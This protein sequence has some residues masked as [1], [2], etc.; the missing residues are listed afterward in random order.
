MRDV[1]ETYKISESGFNAEVKITG[2][3]GQTKTYEIVQHTIEPATAA[4]LEHIKHE[5]ITMLRVSAEEMVDPKQIDALKKR[6]KDKAELVLE[7]KIPGVEKKTKD[8]LIQSLMKEMLG[9]GDIELLLSDPMLEEI[10][11]LSA[12]EPIRV[13][14]RAHGWLQTNVLLK[15]EMQIRD[16]FN[17]IGRRVGRQITNLTP[18]L[19]AHLLTGDRANAVL[20]PIS[21][22]GH[23]LTIRKFARDPWTVTDFIKNNTG[24]ASIFALI[25][26]ATQYESNILVSGGTGSGKTSLL[27]VCMPFMPPAHRI[28]SIEDTRELMLPEYLFWCPLTTRQAN[29]EGKGEVTMSDLLVNALRMRP[30]RI[31]LGEMRKKDQAEVLFE[32]M[33]TGHS[34]YATVHA[35]SVSATIERLE[36]P[37]IEV[38]AN[39][40]TAVNL[41]VVMFRNRRQNVRRIYQVGEF[42]S[43]EEEG[44]K[45]VKANI[46]YRWNPTHD[47]LLPHNK[48]IRLFEELSRHTGMNDVEIDKDIKTKESIL[49]WMVKDNIRSIEQV[50]K[51][52]NMYYLDPELVEN[53]VKK[54]TAKKLLGV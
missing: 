53:S 20:Y 16:Y 18:L 51:I 32:A 1:V 15:D 22:K 35:D 43:A 17:T 28:I 49:Q 37:P 5:L 34:V 33:H 8:F 25:W 13:F 38:P 29:P 23:T 26:F 2:G 11:I 30:D 44:R 3:K 31:V 21:S 12:Y 27:N 52:M 14:H 46:I 9:L 7:Q 4:M 6:F 19:D 41:N 54:G 10:I 36:N 24:S 45:G 42:L 48:P 40:L 50:G 47:K 39:L